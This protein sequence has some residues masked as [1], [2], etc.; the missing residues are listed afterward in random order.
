[1]HRTFTGYDGLGYAVGD[2]IE[3]HPATDL[4]MRGARFGVVVGC[5]LTNKDRVH[6]RMDKCGSV[7][8]AGREDTFRRA[9]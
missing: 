9:E 4:W 1:M 7:K 6:V 5:S 2:R 3:I 8:F